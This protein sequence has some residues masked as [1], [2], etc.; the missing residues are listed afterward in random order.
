MNFISLDLARRIVAEGMRIAAERDIACATVA[1]TDA[2]GALRVFE[3]NDSSSPYAVEFALA[4]ARTV[5]GM[6]C[7][8]FDLAERFSD[9][10][11]AMTSI[12]GAVHGAFMAMGGGVPLFDEE[13]VLLGA[14]AFSGA[15]HEVDHAIVTAAA[16]AV[17]LSTSRKC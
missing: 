12:S 15:P 13:G 2:G 17:G 3:R 8:T 4:K 9:R 7:A 1:V 10:P 14:A 6:G 11:G 16:E 5:I